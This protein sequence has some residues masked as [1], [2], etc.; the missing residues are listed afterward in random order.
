MDERRRGKAGEHRRVFQSAS[1]KKPCAMEHPR[2][3]R[4]VPRDNI[5]GTDI[6]EFALVKRAVAQRGFHY[7][8]SII[9]RAFQGWEELSFSLIAV[10]VNEQKWKMEGGYVDGSNVFK[11]RVGQMN[12]A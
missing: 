7:Q 6:K 1:N 11:R 12:S 4:R 8:R 10:F 5:L 9:V 3:C 2:S